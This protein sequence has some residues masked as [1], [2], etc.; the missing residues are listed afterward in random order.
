MKLIFDGL[1]V[2]DAKELLSSVEI[3]VE[4]VRFTEEH[5]STQELENKFNSWFSVYFKFATPEYMNEH[6]VSLLNAFIAGAKAR[7]EPQP[8]TMEVKGERI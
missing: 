2:E 7:T 8:T 3:K 1:T 4:A 6:R 5:V